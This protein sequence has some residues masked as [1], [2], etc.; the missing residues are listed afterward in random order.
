MNYTEVLYSEY[1]GNP[2]HKYLIALGVLIG[3]VLLG[4]ILD[5]FVKKYVK[6]FVGKSKSKAD[7]IILG[8]IEKPF[9]LFFF[10]IGLYT[11]IHFLILPDAI[12]NIFQ[13]LI[14]SLLVFTFSWF[15]INLIDL[16][17]QHYLEPFTKK[18]ESDLDDHLVPLLRKLIKGALIIIALIMIL[19][20]LGFDVASILAGLG[21][22]GLAFALAAKDL[23]ANLFGGVAIIMDKS[24]SIGQ[25]I[26]VQGVDGTV[27]QIGLRTTVVESL[28][29]TKLTIP[30]A[31]IADNVIENVSKEQARKIALT[32]GVACNT[33][34]KKLQKAIDELKKTIDSHEN[35]KDKTVVRFDNFGPY[36]LDITIV[37]WIT[38]LQMIG[39]TK[40][41]INMAIKQTL[42]GLKIDMPFPTQTV[43]LRK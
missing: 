36:T 29:G 20:D 16:M 19:S 37:Y 18:T 6:N 32:I 27:Q 5:F 3:F 4:R 42:E 41:E 10:V 9:I 14:K 24:F 43:E 11:S 1:F 26:K 2:V 33:P 21:I 40:H 38:N 7:D 17:I 28:D 39:E 34:N 35:V 31:K 25:R 30:N 8:S 13:R 22:G 12:F 15:I 23:L